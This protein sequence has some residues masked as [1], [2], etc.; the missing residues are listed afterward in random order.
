MTRCYEKS[1]L[2]AAP[3]ELER[4]A[5]SSHSV[6]GASSP[7][8]LIDLPTIDSHSRGA[9]GAI[10]VLTSGEACPFEIKRVYWVHGTRDGEIRGRHAHKTLWQLMIALGGSFEIAILGGEKAE[11]FLLDSPRQ[12][13]LLAPG[14]WRTIRVRSS[15]SVLLVAAS[16]PFDEADYIRS[17]ADFLAFRKDMSAGRDG[18][19]RR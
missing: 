13:L 1:V 9:N 18:A 3:G 15:S 10:T 4:S 14:Y 5:A 17:Y 19:L 11:T 2:G 7:V 16:A 8:R 6:G 12:G